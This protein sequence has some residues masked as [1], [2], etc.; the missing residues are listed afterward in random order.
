MHELKKKFQCKLSHET[1]N[2]RKYG[3]RLEDLKKKY[4]QMFFEKIEMKL[5][6]IIHDEINQKWINKQ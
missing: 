4:Q 6:S 5:K 3:K 1:T 2:L